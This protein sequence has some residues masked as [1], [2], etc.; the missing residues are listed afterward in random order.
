MVAGAVKEQL[1]RMEAV[2][3]G[4]APSVIE[5]GTVRGSARRGKLG[6]PN[7]FRETERPRR[8]LVAAMVAAWPRVKVAAKVR[9]TRTVSC[10]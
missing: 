10:A 8:E 1:V 3:S 9:P 2:V 6:L 5:A 7:G 4:S